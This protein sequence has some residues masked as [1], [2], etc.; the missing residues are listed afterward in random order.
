MPS[1]QEL[2]L[3]PNTNEDS[4][5]VERIL[6]AL[7]GDGPYDSWEIDPND[8][9]VMVEALEEGVISEENFRKFSRDYPQLGDL[10]P[11]FLLIEPAPGR[12]GNAR[13][14][15][16]EKICLLLLPPPNFSNSFIL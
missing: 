16:P 9:Q 8:L 3:H 7:Y 14:I 2:I 10:L 15:M 13:N 1:K 5:P 4:D 6:E 12:G 11:K